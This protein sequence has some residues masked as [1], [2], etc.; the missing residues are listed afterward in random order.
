[1][2]RGSQRY[3]YVSYL[4]WAF[5]RL[6]DGGRKTCSS[7]WT[8]ADLE[9]RRGSESESGTN[10]TSVPCWPYSIQAVAYWPRRTPWRVRCR[11]QGL[12]ALVRIRSASSSFT[13]RAFQTDAGSVVRSCGAVPRS[14]ARTLYKAA[15]VGNFGKWTRGIS[16]HSSSISKQCP[17]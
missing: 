5:N 6:I 16:S 17:S 2:V 12:P 8:E 1:M 15:G 11:A 14:P 10:Q 7:G 13:F 3:G 9:A 4:C